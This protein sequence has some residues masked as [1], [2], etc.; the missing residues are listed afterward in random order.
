VRNLIIEVNARYIHGMLNNPD[1]APLASLNR[2]ILSTSAKHETS[3]RAA[4]IGFFP[5][6]SLETHFKRFQGEK[7]NSSCF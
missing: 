7:A 3:L 4:W 5:L 2:W 6:K 1:I